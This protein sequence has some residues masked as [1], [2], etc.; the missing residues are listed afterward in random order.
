MTHDHP[1]LTAL[2]IA[3]RNVPAESDREPDQPVKAVACKQAERDLQ[4]FACQWDDRG[5]FF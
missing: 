2:I 4:E 3:L 1:D 5:D